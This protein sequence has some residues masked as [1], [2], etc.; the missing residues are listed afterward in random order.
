MSK[1]ELRR[2]GP[3]GLDPTEWRHYAVDGNGDGRIEHTSPADSA[4]TLARLI[5]SR[6]S[7]QA[8]IFFHNQAAWYVQAVLTEAQRMQGRCSVHNVD[9]AIALPEAAGSYVNP[10]SHSTG[11][12]TGRIDQGVDFTGT[13]P[14][15]AIGEA[16]I[17]STGAPGWPEEG[18]VLYELLGGP[19]KGKVIFV[20]EGV[21][22][23]VHA[24]ETVKA[25]QQIATFRPGG[26]IE[27]GFADAAGVPLSHA[28]YYEGK[29]TESGLEMFS[30]L[31]A[32]G[33]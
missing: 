31:Q 24:G 19:L 26:S 8:G 25:G 30:L 29:I 9:W 32:L 2:S 21:D 22:A 33:V 28:E 27:T 17:L 15:V 18:G 1:A 16:K 6:G 5:W 14:I 13:G 11:L 7:I 12:V 10:F 20:Y 3:L 4:A 23:T